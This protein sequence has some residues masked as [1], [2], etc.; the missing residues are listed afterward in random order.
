M[1]LNNPVLNRSLA[2]LVVTSTAF[3]FIGCGGNTDTDTPNPLAGGAASN[4]FAGKF[5]GDTLSAEFKVGSESDTLTG[6]ITHEGATYPATAKRN[7]DNIAGTFTTQGK[8][9][10]FTASLV[11]KQLKLESGGVTHI[12]TR[13]VEAPPANPLASKKDAGN[14][15][16]KTNQTKDGTTATK[17]AGTNTQATRTPPANAIA[18][19]KVEMETFKHPAGFTFEH[20]KGWQVQAGQEGILM[21]PDDA[22]KDAQGQPLEMLV[23]GGEDASGISAIEDPQVIQYLDGNI[24][25]MFPAFQRVGE[26]EKL[27]T[28]LGNGMVLNYEGKTA[29][30][31]DGKAVVHATLYRGS[32]IFLTHLG[33]KTAVNA[34][35]NIARRIFSSFG[36]TKGQTDNNLVGTWKRSESDSS[37]ID[38]RG[39]VGGT[40]TKTWVFATDGTVAYGV[41]TAIYGSTSGSGYSITIDPQQSKNISKGTWSVNTNILTVIWDEGGSSTYEYK[42]FPH[43]ENQTGLKLLVP[44]NK[45]PLY[46]IKQ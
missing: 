11:E 22:K 7:G 26:T 35:Q 12:M 34:R 18:L 30:N 40:T 8:E 29:T 28:L 19:T 32:G 13:H 6:T 16:S 45:K 24:K 44:G 14:P 27:Q 41:G 42:V 5:T 33:E 20:P 39:Y 36:W 15:L 46:F 1:L 43:V 37:S 10:A 31:L 17:D 3:L 2:V 4:P 38:S 23:I 21:I 9:L 25:Q